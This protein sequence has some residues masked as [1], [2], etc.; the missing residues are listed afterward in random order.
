[1]SLE[2]MAVNLPEIND[3]RPGGLPLELVLV[4]QQSQVGQVPLQSP[5]VRLRSPLCRAYLTRRYTPMPSHRMR[6]PSA[7]SHHLHQRPPFLLEQVRRSTP[8]Y[9]PKLVLSAGPCRRN[10]LLKS[11]RLSPRRPVR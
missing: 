2:E 5:V 11:T 1:M 7:S 8:M 9:L 6:L 3:E 10:H 4:P